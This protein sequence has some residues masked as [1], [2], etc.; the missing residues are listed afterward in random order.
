MRLSPGMSFAVRQPKL[1]TMAVQDL[2]E[3]LNGIIQG[4]LLVDGEPPPWEGG[5]ADVTGEGKI[6]KRISKWVRQAADHK[7]TPNEL[8]WSGVIAS[9]VMPPVGST[10]TI[11]DGLKWNPGDYSDFDSCFFRSKRQAMPVLHHIGALVARINVPGRKPGRC[12]I[13]HYDEHDRPIAFNFYGVT[14]EEGSTLWQSALGLDHTIP[15]KYF[16]IRDSTSSPVYINQETGLDLLGEDDNKS[17]HYWD[18]FLSQWNGRQLYCEECYEQ[19]S[20][21]RIGEINLDWDI[22]SD[23]YLGRVCQAC[24]EK[25][26][27][28]QMRWAICDTLHIHQTLADSLKPAVIRVDG[29]STSVSGDTLHLHVDAPHI[30]EEMEDE[31]V[32]IAASIGNLCDC[33]FCHNWHA[34]RLRDFVDDHAD[35]VRRAFGFYSPQHYLASEFL[36]YIR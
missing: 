20:P 24:E 17:L 7:M 32:R 14:L 34:T 10:I 35:T 9:K 16:T 1:N 28:H 12:L 30:H 21:Y 33:D 5:W 36:A 2:Y 8:A 22:E 11:L 23:G 29:N 4:D 15:A 19:L 25:I 13:L 6:T 18:D 27:T 26:D 3:Y 31:I